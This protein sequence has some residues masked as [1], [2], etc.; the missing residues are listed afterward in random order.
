[1]LLQQLLLLAT[2]AAEGHTPS[3]ETDELCLVG[4]KTVYIL[5][6]RWG[7]AALSSTTTTRWS[8]TPSADGTIR[9]N[10]LSAAFNGTVECK[11]VDVL[12]THHVGGHSSPPTLGAGRQLLVVSDTGGVAIVDRA[13]QRVAFCAE[14]P[15]AHSAT[16]LPGG[17]VAVVASHLHH[18]DRVAVFD[19]AA[20]MDPHSGTPSLIRSCQRVPRAEAPVP[21]AHGVAWLNRS[22]TL[23]VV[24]GS[25]DNTDGFVYSFALRSTEGGGL[26]G[27]ARHLV[28]SLTSKLPVDAKG[29]HDLSP[30][31][32]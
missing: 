29:P 24:G 19:I 8:W 23:L 12:P 4:Y 30:Y 27:T 20:G 26:A 1:M 6:L 5:P 2:A 22:A 13:S 18:G 14:V 15:G 3:A 32:V 21:G 10:N 25:P 31:P 7:D 28:L 11:P 16:T 17:R 9:S